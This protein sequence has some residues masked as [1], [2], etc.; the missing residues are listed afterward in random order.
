MGR[1]N[2]TADAQNYRRDGESSGD[3][4]AGAHVVLSP[5]RALVVDA[6]RHHYGDAPL[7]R[8]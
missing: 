4:V 5:Y 1:C 7:K 3:L 8:S 2:A 6:H